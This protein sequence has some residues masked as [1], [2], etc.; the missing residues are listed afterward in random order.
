MFR[1]II[2][3]LGTLA[4]TALF[5]AACGGASGSTSA[6]PAPQQKTAL[7]ASYSELVPDELA[8]WGALDGGYFAKNGLDVKLTSI[9]SANGVAALLSG[10]VQIAQLGGSEILSAAAGG[11]DLVILANLVPVYPY[12]FMVPSTIHG[13]ADLKGKKVGVSKFGGSADIATR[14]VLRREGLDPST[15]VTIVETG[16]ASNRVAALRSGAIQGGVSQP[17]ET[18]LL[19]QEGFHSLYDL[20]RLK[21]PAANTVVA[22]TRSFLTSHR[23]VVQA[24]MDALIQ[25]TARE[26][27]DR[28][29]TE[30]L[31][32]K[33][34]KV[35]GQTVLDDTYSFYFK[36]VFPTYPYPRP[37][38]YA[39]AVQV[40]QQ[41]NP[42]LQNF[43]VSRIL[44][45]SFVES[46]ARRKVGG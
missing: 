5:L 31:L 45:P 2:Q 29:F 35:S 22:T 34:E 14:I 26:R 30:Q 13:T 46:A 16:S 19:Q 40:L 27:S 39:D 8:P 43:N 20:A 37:Q 38:Q 21:L 44:D 24:Y 3:R 12:L 18:A 11:A 25:A 4:L 9:S 28:R 42:K 10:E 36:E 23:A 15:D 32:T 7:T 41:K 6:S 33:W 17:P 1:P